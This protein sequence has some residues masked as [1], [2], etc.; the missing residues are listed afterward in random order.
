MRNPHQREGGGNFDGCRRTQTATDGDRAANQQIG[1]AQPMAGPLEHDGHTAHIVAPV[2]L[3]LG[4][5]I[6]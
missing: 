6:V 1:A 3:A 2:I 4:C 5:G